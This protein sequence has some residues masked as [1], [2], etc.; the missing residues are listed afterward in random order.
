MMRDRDWLIPSLMLTAAIV[1][2]A[3]VAMPA[4]S[5]FLPALRILPG[6][7][8]TSALIAIFA[9]YVW[10]RANGADNPIHEI[11]QFLRRE[12]PK[13]L[14]MAFVMF[15][16]GINMIAFMW[17]KPLL[18]YLV[19]FWADP[20][21]ADI[22]HALFL[23]HDPWT[24]LAWLNTPIAGFIYHPVWCI[25]MIFALLMAAWARPSAEKS[26][27][28]LSYFACW[29][30]V[31]PVIHM[32]MPAA[33]PIFYDRMG[34][35]NRFE[36]LDGGPETKMVG[37]YLWAI[38]ATKSFGAGSGISAMP[39]LHVTI[40]CWTVL[41]FHHFARRWRPIAIGGYAIILLLSVSLGW[42]YAIDGI[43]GTIAA[44]AVYASCLGLF[45]MKKSE[46]FQLLPA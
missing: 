45:R 1:G 21:L 12:R 6:W 26:A 9:S 35:G 15:V 23:G 34:Y 4:W 16:A 37:D 40:A 24:Y 36:G 46:K 31:G 38:Y 20:L 33:G 18:N 30:V 41:A 3:L 44:V 2:I 39:S 43:V 14:F 28:L 27:I 5:S 32:L 10:L 13:V 29:C 42:H 7:L 17:M 22:D 19:P 8:G 11:N 25:L